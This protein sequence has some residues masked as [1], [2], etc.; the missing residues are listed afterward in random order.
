MSDVRE[1]VLSSSSEFID[2]IIVRPLWLLIVILPWLYTLSPYY[3]PI[4]RL[5]SSFIETFGG[6]FVFKIT[7]SFAVLLY[8]YFGTTA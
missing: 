6:V 5:L 8:N 4:M 3:Q 2:H 1:F 7:I